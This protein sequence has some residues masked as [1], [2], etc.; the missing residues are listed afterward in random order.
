MEKTTYVEFK[1]LLTKDEYDRL[2]KQF[3]GSKSDFQTNHYFDTT[4][5]SLKALDTSVRVRER[6]IFELSYK[7]KKGYNVDVR[8]VLID[9]AKFDE[10]KETG[11]IDIP[12]IN[13]ELVKLIKDQKLVN[14]LSLSTLRTFLPYKSG[15]LNIDKSEYL[16]VTDYE[17]EYST[18]SYHQGKE[19]F[20]QLISDLQIQYKKS[21][22]K[23]K[24]AYNRLKELN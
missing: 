23:I 3:S 24:R 13:E 16:G 11:T 8:T 12:E 5:F 9:K 22:K 10:I 18:K 14:F 4:R 20:I 7:R 6:E 19:E 2:I 21:D 1:S 17:I 15:V